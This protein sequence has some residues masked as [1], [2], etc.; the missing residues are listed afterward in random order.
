MKEYA[1]IPVTHQIVA[2]IL[3]E[4]DRPNDKI[5][6]LLKSGEL[7]SLRRGLYMSGPEADLP[8]PEPFLIAN[9]LRGPSYV[10]LEAALWHWGIIPERVYEVS[11]VTL[12]TSKIYVNPAGRFSYQHLAAPY[13]SF[14]I[15]SVRLTS[16]QHALVASPEKA[17]CDKII[18]TSGILLRS[19]HQAKEFLIEDM[20]MDEDILRRLDLSAMR[21]WIEDAPKKNSLAMLVK[22]LE[23]L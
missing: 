5:G 3:A 7:Q 21:A 20:R 2:E 15:R 8:A 12:K 6:E 10:S 11:S 1:E 16:K 19:V 23:T 4:Y 17:I 9:H 13:Y 14:G 22:M 18:L